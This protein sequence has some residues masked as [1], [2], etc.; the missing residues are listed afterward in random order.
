MNKKEYSRQY[1]LAHRDEIIEKKKAYGKSR[2]VERT[3]A[4]LKQRAKLKG[5]AFDLEKEDIEGVTHCPVFNVELKRNE[6]KSL[7]N[8]LSIDRK[9]STKGYTKDNIQIM[10]HLAN[11]MK[12]SAT[13]E[14]LIMFANWVLN[15]YAEEVT[16]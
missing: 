8:S 9:D 7:N 5:I 14:E 1:Y 12:S 6:G 3:L 13:K 10:S 15:T 16:K 4:V 11:T 2:P